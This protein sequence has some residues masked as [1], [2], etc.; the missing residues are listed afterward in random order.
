[1]TDVLANYDQPARS[2]PTFLTV[3]CILTFIGSGW[4]LISA[5]MQYLTANAQAAAMTTATQ[6]ASKEISKSGSSSEGAKIANEMINSMASVFTPET[7][8]KSALAA[9]AAALLC[10]AGAVMMWQLKKT[11]FY[12][13]VLGTLIGIV[14]PLLL[15]GSNL[16]AMGMSIIIGFFGVLFVILYGVNLKHMK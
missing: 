11:G 3:L 15:F 13:Y 6:Q 8:K 4:G 2:R 12:L 16:L 9:I 14:T 5:S 1:M 10:L 7:V